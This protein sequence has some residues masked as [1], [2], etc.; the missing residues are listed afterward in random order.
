MHHTPPSGQTPTRPCPLR[1]EPSVPPLPVLRAGPAPALKP[2]G[3][4]CCC[5][6]CCSW[7]CCCW[8]RCCCW[9]C[10]PCCCCC[11]CCC[12]CGDGLPPRREPRPAPLK[13]PP[14]A[15][16][17]RVR[18]WKQC[19]R[20]C[21]CTC[22]CEGERDGMCAHLHPGAASVGS[23]CAGS[24]SGSSVHVGIR[25]HLRPLRL[26]WSGAKG[27]RSWRAAA[28]DDAGAAAAVDAC[29]VCAH[30][31]IQALVHVCACMRVCACACVRVCVCAAGRGTASRVRT[32]AG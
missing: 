5:G 26:T 30:A 17:C 14:P 32:L 3:S 22:V 20:V 27:R 7:S 23:E 6:G 8:Y 15:A 21:R 11:C 1:R 2:R 19:V 29:R 13:A 9:P 12:C 4:C 24:G 25:T 18:Q 10:R 16:M 31:W 28:A